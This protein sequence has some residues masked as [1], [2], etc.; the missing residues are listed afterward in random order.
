MLFR[1]R[2]DEVNPTVQ[3][4]LS[5][6]L[7]GHE[8]VLVKHVLPHGNPH[9]HAY[10]DLEYN[11]RQALRYQVDKLCKTK[12]AA[13]RSVTECDP[14]RKDE[15]IQYLFNTKH[16]NQWL[17]VSST[18][19]TTQ[20]Q[21][22]AGAVAEEFEATR[23]PKE[24]KKQGPTMWEMA[25]ETHQL[26]LLTHV[27]M[28]SADSPSDVHREYA[29]CAIQVCRKHKKGFCDYT[30]QKIVQTAMTEDGSYRELVVNSV[31]RRMAPRE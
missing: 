5:K 7:S 27:R 10:A 8:H 17:L 22:N 14:A 24:K 25:M 6:L 1:L 4:Q 19:D 16:G 26:Y 18:M 2:V 20:H 23:P 28:L 21:A 13:E 15:Y 12:T 30:I 31:V 3:E 29:R 9:F 11:S